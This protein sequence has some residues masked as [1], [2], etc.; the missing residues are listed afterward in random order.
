MMLCRHLD[1]RDCLQALRPR[2]FR[3]GGGGWNALLCTGRFIAELAFDSKM[4]YTNRAR[5]SA[6]FSS[7]VLGWGIDEAIV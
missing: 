3:R 7:M 6:H 5:V 1:F 4:S 2:L